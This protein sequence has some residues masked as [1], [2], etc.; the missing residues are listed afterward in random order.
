VCV[1]ES[2]L[3]AAS[4]GACAENEQRD[5]AGVSLQ[6]PSKVLYLFS[7]KSGM[8][9]EGRVSRERRTFEGLKIIINKGAVF[10]VWFVTG[11]HRISTSRRA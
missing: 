2:A 7:M 1:R 6:V 9:K 11:K 4:C 8:F 10:T 3:T 5:C